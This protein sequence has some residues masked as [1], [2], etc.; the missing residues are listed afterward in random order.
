M[1]ARKNV[2]AH[3]RP[4]A[5]DTLPSPPYNRPMPSPQSAPAASAA[6]QAGR[7]DVDALLEGMAREGQAAVERVGLGTCPSLRGVVPK[8]RYTHE[9]MADLILENPWISQN[10]LAAHFGYSP[11]WVSTIITSD[12]FQAILASRRAEL[13][14]PELRLTLQERFQ[15][16]TTQSLRVLQEKLAKPADQVSDQLALRAA[17]LGAKALGLG[18]NAAPPPAPNPAEYLPALAERLMRL[19]SGPVEDARLIVPAAPEGA[20]E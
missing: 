16:M 4:P 6:S 9:G 19:R 11:A 3:S 14:D 5:L 12:A 17:E 7:L 8:M 2:L 10:Q 20:A 13:V 15:A 18:G 1:Y